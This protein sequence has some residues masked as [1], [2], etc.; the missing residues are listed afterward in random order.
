M[1]LVKT[2]WLL[3][4]LYPELVW[5][6]DQN[7]RCIY[8]TFDDGPIPIVTPF[9]LNIL[10][11]YNAKA[12][13]FCI[14]DNVRKHPD[15]FEQVKADGHAIGNHTYNHLKGWKT[16]DKTYLE[17]FLE[18]DKLMNSK[19]F[20]PPYGRIKRS[21]IKLLKQAKP[22]LQ[23]IMWDVLSGD[24][25]QELSPEKCLENVMSGVRNKSS[26]VLF[27]DSLKAFDRMKY[28]LPKAM[29]TWSKAGYKFKSL[30]SF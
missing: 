16:N 27:H 21:Q 18:A 10:K 25:D 24:F 20:R 23:F 15:V 29:E 9:V 3:K 28:A 19:L 8:L 17:N 30:D 2:P 4:K 1:Y 6:I 12:T 11:E 7:N 22:G 13:F 14:G 5:N 26:I